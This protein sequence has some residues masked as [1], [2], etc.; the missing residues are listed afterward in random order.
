[1]RGTTIMVSNRSFRFSI[2]RVAI[3]AGIA[4]AKPDNKGTNA[5]PWS[6]MAVIGLSRTN[7]TRA[8]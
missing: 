8:R 7:E 5:F 1:M 6:P 4:Q 2:V 3:T